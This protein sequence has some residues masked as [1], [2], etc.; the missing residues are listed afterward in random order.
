MILKDA[1]KSPKIDRLG[2]KI[3]LAIVGFSVL[4]VVLFWLAGRLDWISGWVYAGIMTC[5]QSI[6]ALY[7]WHKNPE[8][9][10]QRGK[11]GKGTKKWDKIIL[12][13][14]GAAYMAIIVVAALDAGR[15]Q[16]SQMP[17]WLWWIGATMYAFFIIGTTWA[18]AIN[19]FFEKTVR[20][21]NDRGHRVIDSGPYRIVRHP[22]YTATI[23]GFIF[24]T[25]FL[26][27]SWWAF[28]P[29]LLAAISLIVRTSLEDLTLQKELSGYDNYARRIRYRLIPGVW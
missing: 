29:A 24:S 5:G 20:I 9:L 26:L 23:I 15:Y 12:G 17:S 3:I 21:Q 1:K 28:A 19:P 8:L 6:S 22:G 18:M 14:F 4:I 10:K 16:W 7:L 27:G 2:I 13:L 25:P 11:I